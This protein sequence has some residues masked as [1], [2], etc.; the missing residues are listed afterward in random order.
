[1][2]S[3]EKLIEELAKSF[4]ESLTLIQNSKK[5]LDKIQNEISPEIKKM[6]DESRSRFEMFE[7]KTQ[8]ILQ[9]ME[10]GAAK[11][12]HS[13]RTVLES[14][15]LHKKDLDNKY[16]ASFDTL[17]KYEKQL[18]SH[19]KSAIDALIKHEEELDRKYESAI[20]ILTKRIDEFN[21]ITASRNEQNKANFQLDDK[22][23]NE[24]RDLRNK[25]AHNVVEKK[26]PIKNDQI[27]PKD[28]ASEHGVKVDVV[29]KLLRDAGVVVRTHMSKVDASEYA[30][31]EK[32]AEEEKLKQDARNKNS[33][34]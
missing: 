25:L 5:Q 23:I 29:M 18:D 11:F 28:W 9:I 3:T 34:N 33:Q 27:K 30:K 26:Q 31:I 12:E 20:Q 17:A 22:A 8:D 16:D 1:M 2:T 13:C 4:S 32:A 24:L 10:Q 14:I 21:H 15:A 6:S 19:Y 7:K